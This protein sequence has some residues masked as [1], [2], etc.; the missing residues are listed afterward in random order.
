MN[1]SF[2]MK[3]P[4]LTGIL[5]GLLAASPALA[6]RSDLPVR[7]ALKNQRGASEVVLT[8]RSGDTLTARISE[9]GSV[10]YQAPDVRL[11]AFRLPEPAISRA[12]AAAAEGNIGEAVRIMRSVVQPVIPYLDLPVDGVI[13]PAFRYAEFLRREKSWA[14]ALSLY[15]AM[16]GSADVELQQHAIA[17]IAYCLARNLQF[18]E[19]RDMAN[20][21]GDQ[22]PRHPGFVPASLALA[23]A[24]AH[25]NRPEG[26]LDY[27]ARASAL[28]RLD[29]ELYP[30]ALL[31]TANAYQAMAGLVAHMPIPS[32]VALKKS[33]EVAPPAPPMPP[34][35]FL[36]VAVQQYQRLVDLFPSSVHVAE[37]AK[38]IEKINKA[39]ESV[40]APP[41]ESGETP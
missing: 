28:S 9:S 13:G 18:A 10:T 38:Q 37:A 39:A 5:I 1:L 4:A 35:D 15:R 19:A 23:L 36:A 7:I 33:S 6:Q 11:I 29:H 16:Q 26:A 30:E 8:G 41:P 32:K 12:E 24:E 31:L 14:A 2:G 3:T 21:F 25:D 34:E 17:W 40:P 22:D 27:A 20:L